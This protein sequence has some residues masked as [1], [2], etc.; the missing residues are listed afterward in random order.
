MAPPATLIGRGADRRVKLVLVGEHG[1][2]KTGVAQ[3]IL[4]QGCIRSAAQSL[5]AQDVP[6][7]VGVDFACKAV[8]IDDTDPWPCRLHLWD[9]SGQERFQQL[10]ESHLRDLTAGDAVVVVYD[11]CDETS[12]AAVD[13][14]ISKARELAREPPQIALIGTK[15]DKALQGCRKISTEEGQCKSDE[16]GAVAFLETCGVPGEQKSADH[17]TVQRLFKRC[18]VSLLRKCRAAT[19]ADVSLGASMPRPVQ[20]GEGL[21]GGI[22][23]T[24]K[25]RCHFWSKSPIAYVCRFPWRVGLKCFGFA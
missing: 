15:L 2:G 3:L 21:E 12:F 7:T 9:T 20:N 16:L 6:P 17:E 24:N 23:A 13:S 18:I 22:A 14:W 4:G 10:V 25:T 19:P 8:Q 1:V 11:I 5:K